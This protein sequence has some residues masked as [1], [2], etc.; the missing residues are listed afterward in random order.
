MRLLIIDAHNLKNVGRVREVFT[1]FIKFL[2][3][4]YTFL[5]FRFLHFY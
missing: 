3:G 5:G 1:V 2:V 4:G